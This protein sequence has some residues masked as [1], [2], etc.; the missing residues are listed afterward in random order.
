MKLEFGSGG[1]AK[2]GFNSVDIRAVE[3]IT[4]VCQAWEIDR[5]VNH[6]TVE[7]IYSRHFFEH[8]T[9]PQA[10]M[11]LKAWMRILVSGGK[12]EMIVPDIKFHMEQFLDPNRKSKKT[13]T[14]LS[15]E[16][17]ALAG[18]CGWQRGELNDVW[19][20]H[21]AIYDFPLLRDLLIDHGFADVK[22]IANDPHHLHIICYKP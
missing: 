18:F 2:E 15:W 12:V 4:Y 10:D 19:D 21:K 3:G 9:F 16:S 11:T 22:R 8:L 13:S 20:V 7:E 17:W 6:N 14:G 1:K 5:H